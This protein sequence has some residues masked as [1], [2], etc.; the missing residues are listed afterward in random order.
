MCTESAQGITA[1]GN[2]AP[3][4]RVVT[5][6][7]LGPK[8]LDCLTLPLLQATSLR[9][10]P[11]TGIESSLASLADASPTRWPRHHLRPHLCRL[12]VP[13]AIIETVP[14]KLVVDAVSRLAMQGRTLL[15]ATLLGSWSCEYDHRAVEVG[16]NCCSS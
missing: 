11:R 12:T 1:P 5:H 7:L 14:C 16:M 3:T 6:L 4:A 8:R 9:Y 15:M 2:P 13:G 10:L